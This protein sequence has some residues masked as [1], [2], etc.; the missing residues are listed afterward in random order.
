MM[1]ALRTYCQLLL[2]L[3]PVGKSLGFLGQTSPSFGLSQGSTALDSM[4]CSVH[5]QYT[6]TVVCNGSLM[7]LNVVW[8]VY[9]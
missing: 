9:Q 6:L 8:F 5:C 4:K 7:E 1:F 3:P 2:L